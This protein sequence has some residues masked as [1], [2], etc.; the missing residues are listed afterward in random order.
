MTFPSSRGHLTR[1]GTGIQ[2]PA[3]SNAPTRSRPHP[4]A[5]N[6]PGRTAQDGVVCWR[7]HHPRERCVESEPG[8]VGVCIGIRRRAVPETA[9][10]AG[11]MSKSDT[12][13]FA[14][15]KRAKRNRMIPGFCCRPEEREAS[16]VSDLDTTRSASR[17]LSGD[18]GGNSDASDTSSPPERRADAVGAHK[19]GTRCDGANRATALGCPH[20]PPRCR[21]SPHRSQALRPA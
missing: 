11:P 14:G 5:W 1:R 3:A 17:D 7:T 10:A 12:K 9:P 8:L 21:S 2:S 15:A 20:A 4:A 13:S 18:A 6:V 19:A 16:F